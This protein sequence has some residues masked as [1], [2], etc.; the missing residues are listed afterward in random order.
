MNDAPM[1]LPPVVRLTEFGGEWSQYIEAVYAYFKV[2]FIDS[3]PMYRDRRVLPRREPM[4]DGKEAAFWHLVSEG[5]QEDDRLPDLRR[6]ER[7]RWPRPV[8]EHCSVPE[9]KLWENERR[10]KKNVCMWLESPDYLVVLGV[11][12]GYLVLLTAYPVEHHHRRR[13]LQAEYE[14]YK[15]NAAR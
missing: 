3:Q 13:V 10:G 14:A 2:D 11:R 1:W 8:I 7:I 9:V 4:S 6:C 12:N 5:E 15:A